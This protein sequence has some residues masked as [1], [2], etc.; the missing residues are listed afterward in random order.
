MNRSGPKE[1]SLRAPALYD[2]R[3]IH[4]LRVVCNERADTEDHATVVAVTALHNDGTDHRITKRREDASNCGVIYAL[5]E[6]AELCCIALSSS[7]C[8]RTINEN[9]LVRTQGK[10]RTLWDRQKGQRYNC[11]PMCPPNI[12][13]DVTNRCVQRVELLCTCG[14]RNDG[15]VGSK[16]NRDEH[17][18]VRSWIP[19]DLVLRWKVNI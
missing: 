14:N 1:D 7:R 4:L 13:P 17:C 18:T 8:M 9:K 5:L 19:C 15:L 11:F 16:D 6:K 10:R 3:K 12:I 2:P